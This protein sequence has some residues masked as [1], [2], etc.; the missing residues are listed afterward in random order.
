MIKGVVFVLVG[1]AGYD[2]L[3]IILLMIIEVTLPSL[4]ALLALALAR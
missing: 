3:L 1:I 4:L 2:G